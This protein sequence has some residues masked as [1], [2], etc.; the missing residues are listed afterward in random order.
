M[1][2]RLRLQASFLPVT[3]SFD[4]CFCDSVLRVRSCV[5]CQVRWSAWTCPLPNFDILGGRGGEGGPDAQP[6]NFNSNA[7]TVKVWV[8]TGVTRWG[9][10]RPWSRD[11]PADVSLVPDHCW[12]WP[13]CPPGII[14]AE[15]CGYFNRLVGNQRGKYEIEDNSEGFHHGHMK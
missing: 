2:Y 7:D 5:K 14:S 11:T 15:K 9:T 1:T 6:G 8:S 13:F 4:K 12:W 10:C 3:C